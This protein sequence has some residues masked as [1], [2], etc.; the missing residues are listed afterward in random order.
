[1]G[2]ERAAIRQAT[3]P[4]SNASSI[5]MHRGAGSTVSQILRSCSLHPI[6]TNVAPDEYNMPHSKCTTT[7]SSYEDVH[8]RT[9]PCPSVGYDWRAPG[10]IFCY[11]GRAECLLTSASSSY[12]SQMYRRL[13]IHTSYS[14]FVV[15]Q[16]DNRS[17]AKPPIAA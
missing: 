12:C 5:S 10:P 11:E 17:S 3:H 14:L 4:P 2:S 15:A 9:Q 7:C 13:Y 8:G 16:P 1:L 6:E